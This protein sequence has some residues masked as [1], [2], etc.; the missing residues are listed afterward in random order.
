[1]N[2]NRWCTTEESRPREVVQW[3]KGANIG[4]DC[5]KSGL[6]AFDEDQVDA[7]SN[8]LGYETDHLQC[9]PEWADISS[10]LAPVDLV[11]HNTGKGTIPGLEVRAEGGYIVDQARPTGPGAIYEVENDIDP[12]PLPSEAL[13][14][15]LAL[16]AR[17]EQADT[18]SRPHRRTV[19]ATGAHRAKV[20]AMTPCSLRLVS[21]GR[22][23]RHGKPWCCSAMLSP[24]A[25]L[26]SPTPEAM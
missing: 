15:L 26:R 13:D 16:K 21:V 5:G 11:I 3:P 9:A 6:V 24:D 7:V 1:M 12:V 17:S 19:P 22:G 10:S 20:S 8:W 18:M 23:L 25:A 2:Q 14:K 4:I